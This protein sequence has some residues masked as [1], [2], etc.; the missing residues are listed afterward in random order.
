MIGIDDCC[1]ALV[2]C[3]PVGACGYGLYEGCKAVVLELG[4]VQI[5]KGLGM[6]SLAGLRVGGYG[7]VTPYPPPLDPAGLSF[8][9]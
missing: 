6:C 8:T 1:L 9:C 7:F 5:K 4:L 2:G 3:G